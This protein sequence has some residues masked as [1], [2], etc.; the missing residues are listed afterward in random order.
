MIFSC[1]WSLAPHLNLNRNIHKYSLW[2]TVGFQLGV[3]IRPD[4]PAVTISAG[5]VTFS[6]E[7]MRRF[8]AGDGRLSVWP[9]CTRPLCGA[10]IL[11]AF[12]CLSCCLCPLYLTV[13]FPATCANY[14]FF[15]L[16]TY[17]V[18]TH[19]IDMISDIYV[20]ICIYICIA[21]SIQQL[22]RIS[23]F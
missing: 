18:T 22:L 23:K 1:C 12:A 5:K 6:G 21:S 19:W 8:V 14:H 7:A 15:P 3:P 16:C 13:N 10:M 9:M 20:Y 11:A 4:L 17:M 2:F